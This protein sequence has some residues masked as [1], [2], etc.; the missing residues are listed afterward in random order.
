MATRLKNVVAAK[1]TAGQTE[2]GK[3][4]TYSMPDDF[5]DGATL[6]RLWAKHNLDVN[7]LPDQRSGL[8]NFQSACRSVETRRKNGAGVEVKVDEV[9]NDA[10]EC[11]Y[12][13]TRMVRDK[14]LKIIEHPK[15]MTIAYDKK[16]E[17]LSIRELEDYDALRGLE[18]AIRTHFA[19]NAKAIPGQKI[20]NTV[21]KVM[22]DIG[23]QNLRRKA[24]GLYFVPREYRAAN[25]GGGT[26]LKPTQ[27]IL[28]GLRAVFDEL[29]GERGDFWSIPLLNDEGASEMVAKHFAINVNTAAREAMEKAIQRVRKGKG[30]GVYPELLNGLW[31]ERRRLHGQVAQFEK[32][33][34][35]EK[36]DIEANLRDLDAALNEL[37]E[38]A[39]QEDDS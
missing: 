39:D 32:L 19:Q 21:R 11:V 5:I 20:R 3:L 30:R 7:D 37:Q 12:Q 26:K 13:I 14:T 23:A 1:N 36:Q 18:D 22:L 9:V 16:L 29:Y 8:H 25:G 35:L 38:L 31:N 4:V 15:A 17:T 28:D 33:V 24:G 27:P 2:L 34:S 10:N 6:V